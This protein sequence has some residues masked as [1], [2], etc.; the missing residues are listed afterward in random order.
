MTKVI[1][2]PRPSELRS[3]NAQGLQSLACELERLAASLQCHARNLRRHAAML[4]SAAR[5]DTRPMPVRREPSR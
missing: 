5:K 4:D 3:A 2:L 1:R